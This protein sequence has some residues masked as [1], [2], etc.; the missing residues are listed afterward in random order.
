MCVCICRGGEWT[1]FLELVC[2]FGRRQLPGNDR[3]YLNHVTQD[4]RCWWMCDNNCM[5]MLGGWVSEGGVFFM[6]NVLWVD[7]LGGWEE[8]MC[9]QDGVGETIVREGM[10]WE[11]GSVG[12]KMRGWRRGVSNLNICTIFS[13]RCK[14]KNRSVPPVTSSSLPSFLPSVNHFFLSI[15]LSIYL[16]FQKVSDKVLRN[17]F[18]V[19]GEAIWH[20][21]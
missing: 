17:K 8:G 5:C 12:G 1:F 16:D 15:Y 11:G 7:W 4:F 21:K 19:Y 10:S 9:L 18:N 14:M 13:R 3:F 2:A 6:K 20:H